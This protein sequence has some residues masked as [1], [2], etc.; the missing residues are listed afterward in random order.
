MIINKK[1]DPKKIIN[2][3][4]YLKLGIIK[5]EKSKVKLLAKGEINSKI[6][7]EVSAASI[8]AK[9]IIEKMGGA[10]TI[11][12]EKKSSIKQAKKSEA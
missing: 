4:L 7:I 6:N 1:R 2:S 11:V 12:D 8:S 10:V 9:Q 5:K 3:A